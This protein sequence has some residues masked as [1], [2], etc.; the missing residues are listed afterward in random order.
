MSTYCVKLDAGDQALLNHVVHLPGDLI[1]V[2][3][4]QVREGLELR[5]S[6]R[7][8]HLHIPDTIYVQ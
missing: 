8:P 6:D 3:R 1:V 5:L 7:V 4:G 2:Q